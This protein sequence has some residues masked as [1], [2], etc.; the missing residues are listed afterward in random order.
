MVHVG[1]T[2]AKI[3]GR[4]HFITAQMP[5]GDREREKARERM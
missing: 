1:M 2:K 4:K 3:K 5:E